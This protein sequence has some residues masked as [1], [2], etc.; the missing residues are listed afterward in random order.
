MSREVIS[1][2]IRGARAFVE[3][4]ETKFAEALADYTWQAGAERLR[5]YLEDL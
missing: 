1:A 3:E 2:V 4:A 5:A